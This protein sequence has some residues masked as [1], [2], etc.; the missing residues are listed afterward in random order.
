M[1]FF[2]W[3]I[4]ELFQKITSVYQIKMINFQLIGRC[5][6]LLI[7]NYRNVIQQRFL[8]NCTHINFANGLIITNHNVSFLQCR[9][10]AKGKDKKKD[11]GMRRTI[12]YKL[13]NI[14]CFQAK[15]KYKSKN[16]NFLKL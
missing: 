2:Y 10:Y 13:N 14:A 15:E 8:H 6:S 11:K 12:L 1:I 4:G 9:S 16:P 5:T 7:N 3:E